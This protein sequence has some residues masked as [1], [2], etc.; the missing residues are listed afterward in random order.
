[1]IQLLAA[2]FY[3]NYNF[4]RLA[5]SDL[6]SPESSSPLVFNIGAILGGLISIL[7]AYGFWRGFQNTRTARVLV[8]LVC[9]AIVLVGFSSLWAGIYPVPSQRH[10]ENPFA[11]FGL[12]PMPFLIAMTFWQHTKARVWLM[13]PVLLLLGLIPIMSGIIVIDRTA[14]DGLLQRLLALA[15]YSPIAIGAVFLMAQTDSQTH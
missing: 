6:G 5:A 11:L 12:L 13:L 4:I 14:Y 10:A 7:G 2:L 3:P 15:T 8:Y 9:T 1:L